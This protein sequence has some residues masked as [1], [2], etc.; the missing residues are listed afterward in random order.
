M[1]KGL[2]TVADGSDGKAG[3]GHVHR[4][5]PGHDDGADGTNEGRDDQEPTTAPVVSRLGEDGTQHSC[6]NGNR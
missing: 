6:A 1:E 2:S 3:N 5:G 4:C